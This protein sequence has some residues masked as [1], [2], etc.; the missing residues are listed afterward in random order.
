MLVER[1]D[2]NL[3]SKRAERSE[4]CEKTAESGKKGSVYASQAD[5]E[6]FD[7]RCLKKKKRKSGA[8][9][10]HV[11]SS[12]HTQPSSLA[13]LRWLPQRPANSIF[14]PQKSILDPTKSPSC[15]L[16]CENGLLYTRPS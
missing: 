2:V 9:A 11:F 10:L 3:L 13:R 7:G 6:T 4:I 15:L 1:K 8:D 5:A 16:L 14:N 12:Y